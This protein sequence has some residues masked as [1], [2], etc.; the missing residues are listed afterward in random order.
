[1]EHTIYN[2]SGEKYITLSLEKDTIRIRLHRYD[3]LLGK[4]AYL[5]LDRRAIPDIMSFLELAKSK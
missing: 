2:P 5:V 3:E 4:P 1:M